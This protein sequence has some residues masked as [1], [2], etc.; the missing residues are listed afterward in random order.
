MVTQKERN[1]K[2]F[3]TQKRLKF[4]FSGF[5][6][7]VLNEMLLHVLVGPSQNENEIILAGN[8][9]LE[10]HLDL[11]KLI[12]SQ[13]STKYVPAKEE[14]KGFVGTYCY[15]QYWYLLELS[16]RNLELREEFANLVEEE[17][18]TEIVNL[19]GRDV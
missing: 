6:N 18:Y 17:N 2:H 5:Y 14:R 8:K 9:Y 10:E 3:E 12:D 15:K 7:E 19:F 1:Q 16:I 4:D 11:F 13:V